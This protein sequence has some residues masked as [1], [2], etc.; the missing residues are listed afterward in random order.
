MRKPDR[1]LATLW[2]E[3]LIQKGLEQR[4]QQIQA[5]SPKGQIS[6]QGPIPEEFLRFDRQPGYQ[7]VQ[8]MRE[9]AAR[10]GV[11][12]P[13]FQVHEG[14]AGAHSQ[15]DGQTVI[16]FA[17]YNYLGLSGH[18]GVT[19]A[20]QEAAARYGTSVSAS[21]IVAGE[22]PLHRQ[23]ERA[24]ADWYGV[25]DALTLVSGHATNVTIIGHLLGPRDLILHDEYAHNSIV[26]G[27][28]L[29]GAQRFS[30]THNDLDHLD[31]LLR[32]HRHK[33]E[34]VLIAVE[35]LYSMDGDFP[36]LPQL[37][38]LKK[39]YGCWLMV[40]EAHSLGVLG[41]TGR[42]I[43]EHFQVD[44]REVD[45][46][47]GTLSKT[48]ASCGGFIAGEQA[49][50]DN[51]RYLAP[52]FLYSVGLAPPLAAAALA[53]LQILQAEP[54]RV[55]TLRERSKFFWEEAQR[56]GLDTG[57]S[58]GYAV[59]P[60]ILG[61]SLQAVRLSMQLLQ[62]GIHV[63]PILYPAVPEQQARLRFFLNTHHSTEELTQ[64]LDQLQAA[65]QNQ[66]L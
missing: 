10:F 14:N 11:Q 32:E 61:S 13:F 26:Q 47:M 7:Q 66:A 48:L 22:R 25:D 41:A 43:A 58:R 16:N 31:A 24:L 35:G 55:Q 27:A 44:P 20:A 21:R 6:L 50:I 45:I 60:L 39:R 49:L 1:S 4:L 15:I 23:L 8:L 12:S 53:A 19:A 40:D 34:R 30:F 28:K 36:D 9:G 17:S 38:A 3:K 51:L 63:Q 52:G 18:P 64:T 42:G 46:W 33:A 56:R 29:S 5:S 37:I 57:L 2:K 59:I 54:Q 65:C 62:R